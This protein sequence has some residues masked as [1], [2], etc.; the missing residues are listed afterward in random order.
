MSDVADIDGEVLPP[1]ERWDTNDVIRQLQE[2]IKW[3][4][5]GITLDKINEARI[6]KQALALG[7]LIDKMRLLEEKPTH[8]L[9]VEDRRKL[10][11]LLDAMMKEAERR[12][13]S[14]S[15]E[16]VLSVQ[17]K[18]EQASGAPVNRFVN[19]DK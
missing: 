5:G 4:L 9:S 8:I 6:D 2:R 15:N 1:A 7:I 17:P 3:I 18:F 16:P 19:L 12:Q 10:P 13:I 14:V 11:E